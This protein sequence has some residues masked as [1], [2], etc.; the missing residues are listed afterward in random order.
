MYYGLKTESMKGRITMSCNDRSLR[1]LETSIYTS[2]NGC[3]DKDYDVRI[4]ERVVPCCFYPPRPFPPSPQPPIPPQPPEFPTIAPTASYAQFINNSTNGA[5]FGAG[6]NISYPS[7]LY[8][9]DT[10]DIVNN[11][12][13]IT[14]S[15]GTSGRAYLVNYQV[16]GTFANETVIGLAVN[17]AVENNSK[18]VPDGGIGTSNSSYIVY[19]PANSVS[20]VSLRV[21][22][23]RI[24]TASP[25]IGTNIS[26]VRI[27]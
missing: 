1:N 6:E 22:S 13:I 26:V 24:T 16:T 9:T 15:G 14:L 27:A 18:I 21:V 2:S 4:I 3:C 19:V 12:G 11:N 10:A 17:G 5:T 8:N 20:T 25:T 7:T 23:G